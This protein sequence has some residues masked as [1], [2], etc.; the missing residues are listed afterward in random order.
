MN[1][2]SW[3]LWGFVATLLLTLVLVASQELRLTRVN[4]PYLLGMM[5]TPRRDRAKLLGSALHLA[6]GYVFSALYVAAFEAWGT[7]T[8]LHGMAIGA[9]HAVGVLV[10]GMP[11]LPGLHPRMAS[12]RA[13]PASRAVLEPP[14]LLAL[15]Y[16]VQTPMVAVVAHL[17]YGVALGLLLQVR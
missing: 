1:V 17:V 16:G 14:G 4:L 9:V 12:H 8:A 15:N 3:L 10:L 5:L 2:Q 7:A 6:N 13:G 11:V